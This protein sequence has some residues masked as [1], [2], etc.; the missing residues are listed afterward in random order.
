MNNV[1]FNQTDKLKIW[2]SGTEE[3][4]FEYLLNA[5]NIMKILSLIKVNLISL[6]EVYQQQYDTY[7]CTF[8]VTLECNGK[9]LVIKKEESLNPYVWKQEKVKKYH[10]ETSI[11]D[12]LN[13]LDYM[14]EIFGNQDE[15]SYY[16]EMY[17]MRNIEEL[18]KKYIYEHKLMTREFDRAVIINEN[19]DLPF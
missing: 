9:I 1:V 10:T 7:I 3:E 19:H 4:K 16:G 13:T 11:N 2:G 14:K 5:P 6:D 17:I 15:D 8:T 12:N 18:E